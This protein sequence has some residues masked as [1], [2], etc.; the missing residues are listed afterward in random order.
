MKNLRK[1]VG[2]KAKI[3]SILTLLALISSMLIGCGSK[4]NQ[5]Q[6]PRK[7]INYRERLDSI[8]TLHTNEGYVLFE[9]F[10]EKDSYIIYAT[11]SGIYKETVWGET[12]T[13][14]NDADFDKCIIKTVDVKDWSSNSQSSMVPTPNLYWEEHEIEYGDCDGDLGYAYLSGQ[15]IC[16]IKSEDSGKVLCNEDGIWIDDCLYLYDSP[17]VFYSWSGIKPNDS[18]YYKFKGSALIKIKDIPDLPYDIYSLMDD[19]SL[20]YECTTIE[21]PFKIAPSG[22]INQNNEEFYYK[23]KTCSFFS[24]ERFCKE[25]NNAVENVRR[26]EMDQIMDSSI[27]LFEF[28]RAFKNNPIKG[29]QLY[30]EGTKMIIFADLDKIKESDNPYYK[31]IVYTDDYSSYV[32]FYTNHYRFAEVDYPIG[33]YLEATFAGYDGYNR[34][35]FIDTT[36]LAFGPTSYQNDY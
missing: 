12:T 11:N 18:E 6:A 5:K 28:T 4:S 26:K 3:Y 7:K 1:M 16:R 19:Y 30:P 14:F 35:N 33:C 24:K 27:K 8:K 2:M 29:Q 25:I 34:F 21:W 15:I 36:P 23:G 17:N 13:L 10:D 20:P 31:Y 22:N 32:Y 9:K